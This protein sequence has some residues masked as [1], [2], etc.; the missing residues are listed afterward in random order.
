MASGRLTKH[1]PVEPVNARRARLR[2]WL[3][4]RLAFRLDFFGFCRF[5]FGYLLCLV[6][7]MLGML[8]GSGGRFCR[9]RCR[10]SSVRGLGRGIRCE[11]TM[12]GFQRRQTFVA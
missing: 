6:C 9:L 3:G 11:L 5:S 8:C 12:G 1:A 2:N 4:L 7:G 10:L